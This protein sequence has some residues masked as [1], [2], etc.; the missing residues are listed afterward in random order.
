MLIHAK[1]NLLAMA[2][3][4]QFDVI[5]HGCNCQADMGGGIAAQI[6]AQYPRV[7]AAD[8]QAHRNAGFPAAGLLGNY[9]SVEVGYGYEHNDPD[10]DY[11][12][13]IVNGYTQLNGGS[14]TFSYAA[15]ELVLMKVAAEFSGQRIGLPYIGCG[16]AGGDQN[17]IVDIFQLF[18]IKA[19]KDGTTVTLVEFAP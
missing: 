5:V 11:N 16:I 1:G 12:F 2:Q 10:N 17:K 7:Q 14:G 13:F 4:G 9:S 19:A 6:A 15:L 18:A 8:A 3:A